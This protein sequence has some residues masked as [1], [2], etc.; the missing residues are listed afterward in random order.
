MINI[1]IDE[2][3]LYE[4]CDQFS[5][6]A[7]RAIIDYVNNNMPNDNFSIGDIC[8]MFSEIPADWADDEDKVIATLENG[9]VLIDNEV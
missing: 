8:I 6:C 5:L 7:C 9:S 4:L 2:N 3:L 1:K